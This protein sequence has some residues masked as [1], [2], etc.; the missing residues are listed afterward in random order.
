[1]G[2]VGNA[3]ATRYQEAAF[4]AEVKIAGIHRDVDQALSEPGMVAIKGYVYSAV[5]EQVWKGESNRLVAFR[6]GLDACEKKLQKGARYLIFA[7]PDIYGRLQ[8][9]SCE[10]AVPES[11]AAPL[12][13]RMKES[14]LQ[15]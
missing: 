4:V 2:S 1:M 15:G 8:L 11:E 3:I 7:S 10:A 14:G 6:R 5:S 9:H 13:A 12:L